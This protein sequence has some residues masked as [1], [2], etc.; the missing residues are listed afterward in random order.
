[1]DAI[2]QWVERCAPVVRGALRV[3]VVLVLVGGVVAAAH[4]CAGC[5]ASP[6]RVA[7][8]AA[9]IATTIT[10]TAGEEVDAARDRALDAVEAAHPDVGPERSAALDAEAARWRPAGIALDAIRAALLAWT[11]AIALAHAAGS[12]AL[13]PE[14]VRLA[15][16][17]VGLYDALIAA[18]EELGVDD[19][20]ALPAEVRALARALGG[21]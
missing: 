9:T 21:A 1:M 18:V 13:W 5:G 12:D 19:L 7:A 20:P 14:L 17:V 10:V 2:E 8:N 15:A 11:Q 6:V 4:T 16:R 3:V